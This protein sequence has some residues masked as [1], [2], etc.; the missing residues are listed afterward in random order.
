MYRRSMEKE[1]ADTQSF[2]KKKLK[3]RII[4]DKTSKKQ[5]PMSMVLSTD[6]EARTAPRTS[7][8]T[9]K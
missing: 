2:L 5:K 3:Q 7:K 6:P 4:K 9:K 8:K 1:F